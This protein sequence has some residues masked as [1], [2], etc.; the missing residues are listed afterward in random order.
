MRRVKEVLRQKLLLGRTHRE[1]ASCLGIG[2]GT[3]GDTVGRAKSAKLLDWNELADLS[4]DELEKRLYG[5]KLS[6]GSA[7]PLPDAAWID[8]EL[9]K[10]GVTLQLL[11]LEYLEGNPEGYRYTQFCQSYKEWKKGQ[12]LT[13]RQVHLAG[14]KLFVDFSGKKPQ[15][16]DP[17]T[18]EVRDVEL[19]VAVLGASNST[20]AKAVETQ[21]IRDWLRCH[22]EA[23]EYFGGV[24]NAVVPD[25][26]KAGVTDSC[27][28]EPGV[29]R[30]YEEMCCHYGTAPLPARQRKPK[31]KAKVE[32]GVLVAQ[33][34]I[35]ARLRNQTFHSLAEL[36]TRIKELLIELNER[37]MRSYG[38]SRRE[39][40][41]RLDRPALRPL[42]A[43]RFQFGQWHI[44]RKPGIDYHVDVEGHYYSVPYEL[45]DE[46]FDARVSTSI[47]ELWLRGKRITSHRRSHKKGRHTTNPDHMPASHRAHAEWTP[48][49]LIRWAAKVGPETA[50]FV[51]LLIRDRPHPEQGYRSCLGI[52]RLSKQYGEQRLEVACARAV[53]VEARSYK[54]VAA[55]LNNGIDRLPPATKPGPANTN[56]LP[57]HDNVRGPSYYEEGDASAE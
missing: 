42:P 25:Q 14:D 28:Y 35:L 21:A 48:S 18:G 33:R 24:T 34:W 36:N 11:H 15:L 30:T 38:A 46:R 13:M 2:A 6:V 5:P 53:A 3:V 29:Q 16:V 55:I 27:R 32:A 17:K 52:M 39:L 47:V 50:T 12:G 20:F 8:V 9:R 57:E 7:R 54:H 41:E 56:T 23:F 26:L 49:R 37:K 4:E 43:S 31:D 45:R 44:N 19:F 10:R 40:F 22:E 1:I 51:A